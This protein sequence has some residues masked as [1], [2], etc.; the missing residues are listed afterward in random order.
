MNVSHIGAMYAEGMD[1][2]QNHTEAV[3]WFR[4][5]FDHVKSR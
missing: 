1:T 2:P 3:Q 4:T 5:P